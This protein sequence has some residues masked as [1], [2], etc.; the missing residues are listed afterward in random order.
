MNFVGFIEGLDDASIEGASV[1]YFVGAAVG[2]LPVAG[3]TVGGFGTI[4]LP[5]V[6]AVGTAVVG[7]KVVGVSDGVEVGDSLGLVVVGSAVGLPG[8][9][10]GL[11]VGAAVGSMVLGALDG[12]PVGD[13]LGEAVVG[14][15]VGL[16]G[17]AV[18]PD[19]GVAV[20]SKVVG[21]IDGTSVGCS[22]G[23]AVV[24]SAVGLPGVMVGLNVGLAVGL[25]VYWD[26]AGVAGVG[27]AVN[28][29]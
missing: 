28:G 9:A 8:V 7:G 19:D 13:S 10:V 12:L 23:P 3:S 24:G 25:L 21:A 1:G 14:F 22:L 17:V 18:G 2:G 26:G 16:P 6:T 4:K 11:D 29:A 5:A 15:A 27:N 20:G